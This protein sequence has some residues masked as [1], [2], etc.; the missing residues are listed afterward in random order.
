MEY[1]VSSMIFDDNFWERG[2]VA[3]G[4]PKGRLSKLDRNQISQQDC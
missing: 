2:S 1:I 3:V 4:R